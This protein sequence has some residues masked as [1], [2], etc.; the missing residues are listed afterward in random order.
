MEK[1]IVL[2]G[3]MGVGKSTVG[4]ILAGK[5]NRDFIDVDEEIEKLHGM[6]VTE[7]FKTM[8]EPKFRQMEREFIIG[9]CEN[10]RLKVVSLGGGAFMQEEVRE[11][12]LSSSIVFFLDLSWEYW[13]NRI[14]L[15]MGSR[16]V[17]Q[18]KSLE[19][20]EQ[21]FYARRQTY[22]LSHFTV[23]TNDLGP[24][25]AADRIIQSLKPGSK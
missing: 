4:Q 16:P 3:F 25:E 24:E 1:N 14:P 15:I 22:S 6:P 2:T 17:L 18:Q 20:I 5:L 12:C 19:E 21:L 13:K 8:G 11:A 9:L 7:I 10:S 23:S